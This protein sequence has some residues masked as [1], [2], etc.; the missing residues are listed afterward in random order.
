VGATDPQVLPYVHATA[1]EILIG[2]E[3]FAGG[4]YT[5]RLPSQIASLLAQ[6]WARWIVSAGILILAVVKLVL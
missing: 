1:D 6:D 3:M 2:E 5:A 4:A